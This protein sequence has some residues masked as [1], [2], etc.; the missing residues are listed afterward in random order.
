[1][2][3]MLFGAHAVDNT[4]QTVQKNFTQHVFRY[5]GAKSTRATYAVSKLAVSDKKTDMHASM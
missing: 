1:M 4:L 3:L 2:K 5:Y